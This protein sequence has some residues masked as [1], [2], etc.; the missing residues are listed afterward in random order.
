MGVH[1][2]NNDWGGGCPLVAQVAQRLRI[3]IGGTCKWET[4]MKNKVECQHVDGVF[5]LDPSDVCCFGGPYV[6]LAVCS[7]GETN[8]KRDFFLNYLRG[9]S[10]IADRFCR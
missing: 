5:S 1:F 7:P 4:P 9:S 2:F 3:W 8:W 6:D 10:F